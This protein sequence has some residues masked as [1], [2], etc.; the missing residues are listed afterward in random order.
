VQHPRDQ[1]KLTTPNDKE[2]SVEAALYFDE[3]L[4]LKEVNELPFKEPE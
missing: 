2:C 1:I 3:Q 4:A